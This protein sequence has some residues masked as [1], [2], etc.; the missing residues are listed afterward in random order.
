ME[1][2]EKKKRKAK[3]EDSLV[4][5]VATP[6]VTHDFQAKYTG[7]GGNATTL[8]MERMLAARCANQV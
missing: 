7:N 5:K 1:K 3:R 6:A 4:S 8:A 2:E